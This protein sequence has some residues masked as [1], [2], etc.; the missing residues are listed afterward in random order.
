MDGM[1][2][3]GVS[4]LFFFIVQV[5]L[6]ILFG[7]WIGSSFFSSVK[8]VYYCPA[9]VVSKMYK[10]EITPQQ[11]K[12]AGTTRHGACGTFFKNSMKYGDNN[13][14]VAF[15]QNHLMFDGEDVPAGATGYFGTQTRDAV[16]AFQLKYAAQILYPNHLTHPTGAVYSA[17][18]AQL[19]A[20]YCNY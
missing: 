8:T 7:I 14:D 18:L 2:D 4:G 9:S 13:I 3:W 6:L 15:L 20:L 1:D 17:T 12:D 10:D 19:N 5:F 16:N 11:V